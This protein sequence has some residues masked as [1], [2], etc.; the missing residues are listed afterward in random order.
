MGE[1]N[2][3]PFIISSSSCSVLVQISQSRSGMGRG[4]YYVSVMR[5]MGGRLPQSLRY[6]IAKSLRV[7]GRD[8]S[9]FGLDR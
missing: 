8:L 3:L 4:L 7:S 9:P 1:L 2:Y 5:A 6:A